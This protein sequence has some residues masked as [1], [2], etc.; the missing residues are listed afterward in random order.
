MMGIGRSDLA[1]SAWCILI[2]GL[3]FLVAGCGASNEA[4]VKGKVVANGQPVTGGSLTFSPIGN[5]GGSTAI[6]TV[7]P[8]GTFTL[9]ADEADGASLGKHR[10][11]YTA[12]APDVPADWTGEGL[13]PGVTPS[14]YANLV[15]KEGEVEL[16]AGENDLTVELVPPGSP[17]G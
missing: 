17:R 7:N 15:P 11:L 8:D 10:V 1:R 16:K 12:P 9:S 14:P 5:E 4:Q 3:A 13:P 6:G 2:A